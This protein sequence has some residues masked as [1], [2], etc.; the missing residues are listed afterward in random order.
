ML[1]IRPL[2]QHVMKYNDHHCFLYYFD[3]SERAMHNIIRGHLLGLV[4]GREGGG[5]G[6][7]TTNVALFVQST[8]ANIT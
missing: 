5:G 1:K 6:V 2:N 7:V 3:H 4:A 8:F